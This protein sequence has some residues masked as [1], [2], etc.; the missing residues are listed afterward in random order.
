M[1]RKYPQYLGEG[2]MEDVMAQCH[3]PQQKATLILR[4]AG[5]DLTHEWYSYPEFQA[6]VSE[7]RR[8]ADTSKETK[9]EPIPNDVYKDVITLGRIDI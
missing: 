4:Q 1:K 6:F 2:R 9:P 3:T 7:L 8:V 5:K